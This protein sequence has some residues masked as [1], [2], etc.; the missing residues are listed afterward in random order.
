MQHWL[1]E[2]PQDKHGR[3]TYSAE[4]IGLTNQQITER[5]TGL[6]PTRLESPRHH[7]A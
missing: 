5:F 4:A 2:Y 1:T 6:V 3:H 7:Q